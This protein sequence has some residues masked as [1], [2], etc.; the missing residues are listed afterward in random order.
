MVYIAC[1]TTGVWDGQEILVHPC[2]FRRRHK[3][4]AGSSRPRVSIETRLWLPRVLKA[5]KPQ[6]GKPV[7]SL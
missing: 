4:D 3:K 2:L 6:T 1:A 7:F 5:T